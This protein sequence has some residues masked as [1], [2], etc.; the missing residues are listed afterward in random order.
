VYHPKCAGSYSIKNVLPALVPGM[1][2]EGMEVRNA[3]GRGN[4]GQGRMRAVNYR[5]ASVIA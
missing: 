4:R 5:T 1:A 2:Y 3:A